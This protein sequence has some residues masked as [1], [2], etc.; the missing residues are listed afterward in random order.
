MDQVESHLLV[1]LVFAPRVQLFLVQCSDGRLGNPH[2]SALDRM[3]EH[4][5]IL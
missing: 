4:V 1:E 3:R 5:A 2:L